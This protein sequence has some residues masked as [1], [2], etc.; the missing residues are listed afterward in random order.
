MKHAG[1]S[2]PWSYMLQGGLTS[3]FNN[4]TQEERTKMGRY[5]AKNGLSKVAK[6]LSAL[7]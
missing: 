5:V 1:G 6:H 4:Y 3:N 7:I 2:K